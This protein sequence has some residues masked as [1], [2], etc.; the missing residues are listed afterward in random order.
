MALSDADVF[1]ANRDLMFAVA[2]RMLG[3]ITDA[4]DAI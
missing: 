2:Y 3:T 4:E 1:E